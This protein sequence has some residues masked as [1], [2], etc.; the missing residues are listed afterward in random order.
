MGAPFDMG[1]AS[2]LGSFLYTEVCISL[3]KCSSTALQESLGQDVWASPPAGDGHYR[4]RPLSETIRLH[5]ELAGPMQ[6]DMADGFISR[7]NL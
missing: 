2:Y 3:W 4:S 6:S 7:Q 5:S 1:E